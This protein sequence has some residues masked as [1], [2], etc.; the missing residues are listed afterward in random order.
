MLGHQ[1]VPF[2]TNSFVVPVSYT[3]GGCEKVAGLEEDL[4]LLNVNVKQFSYSFLFRTT[5]YP[6][7]LLESPS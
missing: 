7:Q 2:D 3:T 5:V 1:A 6:S 4:W